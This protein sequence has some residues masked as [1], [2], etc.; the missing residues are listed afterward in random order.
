M[1]RLEIALS[2]RSIVIVEKQG[3]D[4]IIEIGILEAGNEIPGAKQPCRQP[5]P[6]PNA[7]IF[8]LTNGQ[9]V[10]DACA[11]AALHCKQ[12]HENGRRMPRACSS[13]VQA[14][15][16]QIPANQHTVI[17]GTD[18]ASGSNMPYKSMATWCPGRGASS[19]RPA[20]SLCP[21]CIAC[22]HACRP[23]NR[24]NPLPP[25]RSVA[26][27]QHRRPTAMKSNATA[28]K[29]HQVHSNA[30]M[31]RIGERDILLSPSKPPIRCV[32]HHSGAESAASR[33]RCKAPCG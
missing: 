33:R 12:S 4:Q 15:R 10:A 19:M 7:G 20:S 21:F 23:R 27:H 2:I 1:K 22:E 9:L 6:L 26:S 30:Q 24:G 13:A 28:A 5:C 31:A 14:T 17:N 32:T 25:K 3:R 16:N 29:R 11:R 18:T 8:P